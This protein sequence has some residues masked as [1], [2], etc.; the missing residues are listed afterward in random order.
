MG[1]SSVAS[2]LSFI[3][4]IK[5]V[6]LYDS[7]ICWNLHLV[8]LI[9]RNIAYISVA[10]IHFSCEWSILNLLFSR[11]LFLFIR[12]TSISGHIQV[13]LLGHLMI[14]IFYAKDVDKKSAYNSMKLWHGAK[15]FFCFH[16]YGLYLYIYKHLMGTHLNGTEYSLKYRINWMQIISLSALRIHSVP[17][18]CLMYFFLGLYFLFRYQ[19][20]TAFGLFFLDS[21]QVFF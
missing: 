14:R 12:L 10:Y 18:S 17:A 16:L 15:L 21:S 5:A 20:N 3:C 4:L 6:R 1:F 9:V 13:L 19:A 8:I 7:F 11:H 2:L